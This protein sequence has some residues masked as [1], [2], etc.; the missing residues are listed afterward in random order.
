MKLII[1]KT[2]ILKVCEKEN[3]NNISVMNGKRK[4][5]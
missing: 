1:Y 3:K 2:K 4:T 5:V